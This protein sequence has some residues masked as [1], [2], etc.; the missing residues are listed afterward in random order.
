MKNYVQ[1]GCT[2]TMT[3]P[4]GGVVSGSAYLIGGLIVVA[5]IS[6]AEGQ[7]FEGATEGVFDLPKADSQA[8][9]EGAKV[10]WDNTNKVCTTTA[11]SN[12]LMGCA[13]LA[14]ANTAGLTTGRVRLNGTV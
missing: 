12:T 1:E 10:Y 14:V 5:Q 3:A 7:P 9:V 11:T 2:L 13:V 4:A 8:W 6:A